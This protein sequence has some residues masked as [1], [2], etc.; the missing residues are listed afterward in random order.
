[1]KIIHSACQS[2][3]HTNFC[4]CATLLHPIG[5]EICHSNRVISLVVYKHLLF[6]KV[7][8][9]VLAKLLNMCYTDLYSAYRITVT[10]SR[11]NAFLIVQIHPFWTPLPQSTK[12]PSNVIFNFFDLFPKF[13]YRIGILLAAYSSSVIHRPNTTLRLLVCTLW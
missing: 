11:K 3:L 9:G 4:S 10:I 7:H 13:N 5:S 8:E 12:S 1:M 6:R 2:W